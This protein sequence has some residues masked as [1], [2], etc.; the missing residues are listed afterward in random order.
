MR[1]TLAI[2]RSGRNRNSATANWFV[3]FAKFMGFDF[4]EVLDGFSDLSDIAVL[5]IPPGTAKMSDK[6]LSLITSAV[7]DGMGLLSY[8]DNSVLDEKGNTRLKDGR[9]TL[10]LADVLGLDLITER[11]QY[12]FRISNHQ[13]RVFVADSTDDLWQCV[14]LTGED[15]PTG[16]FLPSFTNYNIRTAQAFGTILKTRTEAKTANV[17][18]RSWGHTEYWADKPEG[19]IFVAINQFGVG[20]AA[21]ISYNTLPPEGPYG[22]IYTDMVFYWAF[23][24]KLLRRVSACPLARIVQTPAGIPNVFLRLD[25]AGCDDGY[26]GKYGDPYHDTNRVVENTPY[27]MAIA[28]ETGKISTPIGE[29]RLR[30]WEQAGNVIVCHTRGLHDMT[31]DESEQVID[32]HESK[33]RL[34]QILGHPAIFW[35]IPGDY[36]HATENTL[37]LAARAGYQLCGEFCSLVSEIYNPQAC[38]VYPYMVKHE[39]IGVYT[40][41]LTASGWPAINREFNVRVMD[42]LTELAQA[43]GIPCVMEFVTH[44][45]Q[46]M[47]QYLDDWKAFM[48]DLAERVNSGKI[49]I[50]DLAEQF[51]WVK[52]KETLSLSAKPDNDGLVITVRNDNEE[53]SARQVTIDCGKAIRSASGPEGALEM[54]GE[55]MIILPDLPPRSTCS[56]KVTFA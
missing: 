28:V 1:S 21:Y 34:E 45:P 8:F 2:W 30:A 7:Q 44:V 10:G 18:A 55:S 15:F 35:S 39:D 16:S 48:N 51:Q 6:E 47:P 19:E 12:A 27:P 20:R 54:L 23:L 5:I 53:L 31:V 40:D 50:S 46:G 22:L 9:P 52:V 49:R 24:A 32:L 3:R 25:D 42:K 14:D 36:E 17:L 11:G 37:R 38:P 13:E 26:A 29:D 4:T 43:T 56:V 33:E 41:V